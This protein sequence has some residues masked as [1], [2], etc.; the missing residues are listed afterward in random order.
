MS[1]GSA[2]ALL[3]AM[4]L[5]GS[6]AAE[7]LPLGHPDFLPTPTRPVSYLGDGSGQ[8]P[9]A[10][11]VTEWDQASGTNIVWRAELPFYSSAD[12]CIVVGDRVFSLS[13]RCWLFCHDAATGKELWRRAVLPQ[14]D[15]LDAADAQTLAAQLQKHAETLG[16]YCL[17]GDV[18]KD[19]KGRTGW[20]SFLKEQIGGKDEAFNA[21]HDRIA[22]LRSTPMHQQEDLLIVNMTE[23]HCCYTVSQMEAMS[24][25][26]RKAGW[27]SFHAFFEARNTA[28]WTASTFVPP[29]SDGTHVYVRLGGAAVACYDLEGVQRWITWLDRANGAACAPILLYGDLLYAP[30]DDWALAFDKRTGRLRTDIKGARSEKGKDGKEKTRAWPAPCPP[31]PVI[32]ATRPGASCPGNTRAKTC[33]WVVDT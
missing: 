10:T 21:W 20:M 16:D 4:V 13:E 33:S 2:S 6:L 31:D 28:I 18:G 8:W 17:H 32:L 26:L 27:T 22:K 24:R 23:G 14:A 5:A 3:A 11:P 25:M 7:D 1:N 9:G 19:R 12:S 15:L 30:I 29:V